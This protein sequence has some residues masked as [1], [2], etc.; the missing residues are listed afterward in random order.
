MDDVV[1]IILAAALSGTY[2]SCDLYENHYKKFYKF[3]EVRSLLIL[4]IKKNS[5]AEY[6]SQGS[7]FIEFLFFAEFVF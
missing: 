4:G 6:S 7:K 2:Y 3:N 1:V 5:Y